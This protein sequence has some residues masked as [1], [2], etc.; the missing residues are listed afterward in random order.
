MR[1]PYIGSYKTYA[2]SAM[3]YASTHDDGPAPGL[4]PW[5]WWVGFWVVG[6]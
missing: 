6:G 3:Y 2:P 4:V 5:W 1:Q